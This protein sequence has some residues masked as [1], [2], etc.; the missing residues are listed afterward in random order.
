MAKRGKKYNNASQLVD[1]REYELNEAVALIKKIAFAKFDETLEV[2]MRLGVNPKYAD[3]MVRGTVVLPHGL[4]KSKKVAVITSAEKF[5]EAQDAGA[6]EVGAEDLVDKI[7]KG[8]LDFD[9]V[10]A[11]PDM[12]KFVGRLGKV[13]GPRGLMPNPK[14]GTVTTEVG[15][16]ITEIKAGKVEFRVDKGG[17]VHAPVGKLS[18]D[19]EKLIENAS[20]FI[21]AVVKAKPPASKGKYIHSIFACSSM[22]PGIQISLPAFEK[23][24]RK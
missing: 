2:S 11:T 20:A 22:G 21:D 12:M 1:L 23:G 14:T 9:A 19:V 5:K 18:F 13:L 4:G 10:V 24:A 17:V 3:Q 6:D 7:S 8:Y 16:A 15:K